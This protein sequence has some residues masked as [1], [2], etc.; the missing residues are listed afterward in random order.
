V[1][2]G[3]IVWGATTPALLSSFHATR[4]P[5]GV[6]L[7]WETASEWRALCFVVESMGLPG[8]I[9]VEAATLLA[10]GASPDGGSYRYLDA[11]PESLRYR[12]IEIDDRRGSGNSPL[13]S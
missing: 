8:S 2:P 9:A 12:Q 7:E 13:E 11:G 6:L 1:N 3:F 4:T 5:G 10:K